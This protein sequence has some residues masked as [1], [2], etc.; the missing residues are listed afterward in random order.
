MLLLLGPLGAAR[1][2]DARYSSLTLRPGADGVLRVR[3]VVSLSRLRTADRAAE[4]LSDIELRGGGA[5]SGARVPLTLVASEA[6][7]DKGT[8]LVEAQGAAPSPALYVARL[9]PDDPAAKTLL[10]A[11]DATG[12]LTRQEVLD[13]G[14]PS[15]VVGGEDKADSPEGRDGAGRVFARFVAAGMHHIFIGPDHILFV[16]ALLLLGGSMKTLLKTVTAFTVAHSVT[17]ALAALDIWSP[18]PA[19]IEPLIAL[20]IVCVG[21]D[22]LAFRSGDRDLRPLLAFG[23]GFVHGFGFA[24]VLREAALPREALGLSLLS[25]N[26]GVEIGQACIVLAVAPALALLARRRPKL[27][28]RVTLAGSILV[29]AAG[30]FWF[31][32]RVLYPGA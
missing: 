1:A 19:V 5:A 2:H 12:A 6:A 25:F 28:R 10:S 8:L 24:G 22:N 27:A 11:Y 3:A 29:I 18:A 32:Q 17:L 23:F 30:A 7:P 14:H 13:A 16:V 15:V 26:V 4:A 20:S 21:A 9:Y 31:A